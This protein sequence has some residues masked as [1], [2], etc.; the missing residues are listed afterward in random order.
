MYEIWLMMNIVWEI[1]LD[2][3]PLLAVAAMVWLALMV[4]A[5]R[6]RALPWRSALPMSLG[7]AAA[8]A[9]LAVL[10][11]PTLTKSSLGELRYWVDWANLTGVAIGIGGVALAFAWPLSALRRRP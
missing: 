9:L 11:V 1:A 3:W 6:R 7:V 10:S 2:I 8:A 5:W 4:A